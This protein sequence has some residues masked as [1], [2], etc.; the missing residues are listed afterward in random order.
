MPTARTLSLLS[1]SWCPVTAVAGVCLT[2]GLVGCDS[3]GRSHAGNPVMPDAPPR[4]Q[5]MMAQNQKPGVEIEHINDTLNPAVASVAPG[6]VVPTSGQFDA[7]VGYLAN[8]IEGSQVIATVNGQ[9]ILADDV[10][11]K[12][13]VFLTQMRKKASPEE[14]KQQRLLVIKRD[15]SSLVD[16]KLLIEALRSTIKPEQF[17]SVTEQLTGMWEREQLSK[18][19]QKLGVNTRHEVELAMAEK[20]VS[21]DLIRDEFINQA[22]AIQFLQQKAKGGGKPRRGELLAYYREHIKDYEFKG[23]VRWQHIAVRFAQHGDKEKGRE[24]FQQAVEE[25]R[26]QV[27]FETVAKKYSDAPTKIDGGVWGWTEQGSLANAELEKTVWSIPIGL[28]GGPIENDQEIQLVRVLERTEAGRR[29]FN[30]VQDEI[31]QKIVI[32]RRQNASDSVLKDLK[33]RAEIITIFDD[34]PG[35]TIGDFK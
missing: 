1:R 19:K 25:L 31:E 27:P 24:V 20:G 35:R 21:L 33:S 4:K 6:S 26:K 14:Y 32:S 22:M 16:R 23:R 17:E 11:E 28:I 12:Y 5:A 2:I 8:E 13:S 10:L 18:I 15:L 3:L 34:V 30:E 9:P 29:P 7:P